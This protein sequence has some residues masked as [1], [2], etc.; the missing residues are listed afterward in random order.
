[1]STARD[2]VVDRW[3]HYAGGVLARVETD[4]DADGRVD[5][6]STYEN[7]ILRQTV[8]DADGDGRP[9]DVGDAG[10]GPGTS[11]RTEGSGDPAR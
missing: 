1:M 8:R 6:W 5:T 2:G 7:G 4:T 10:R 9:D 11:F 3:E